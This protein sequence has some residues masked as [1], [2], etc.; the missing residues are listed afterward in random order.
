MNA[1]SLVPMFLVGLAGS[2]HCIGM[3][4]GIVGALSISGGA[5]APTRPVIAIAVARP[6]LQT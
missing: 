2:V 4:G 5:P 6:A 1:L 3:C